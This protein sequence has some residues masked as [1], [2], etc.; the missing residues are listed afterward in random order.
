MATLR[1]CGEVIY[2]MVGDE[3][4]CFVLARLAIHVRVCFFSKQQDSLAAPYLRLLSSKPFCLHCS[5]FVRCKHLQTDV[6]YVRCVG[7][8]Q[9]T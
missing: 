9:H 8:K 6:T 5:L 2:K 1:L 4:I 3:A 7:S